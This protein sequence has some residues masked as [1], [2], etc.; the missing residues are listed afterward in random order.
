[1]RKTPATPAP[2]LLIKVAHSYFN[3][4]GP[5]PSSTKGTFAYQQMQLC[6]LSMEECQDTDLWN[7]ICWTLSHAPAH[8]TNQLNQIDRIVQT[9]LICPP[10]H[11]HTH[12][13]SHT[14]H[15]II[16]QAIL[17][18]FGLFTKRACL[19]FQC[20]PLILTMA[21]EGCACQSFAVVCSLSLKHRREKEEHSNISDFWF[22]NP[23]ACWM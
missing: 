19:L 1:M 2:L 9:G 6:S 11:T 5:Y 13:H 18:L 15:G 12:T 4:E 20:K 3:K 23:T 16:L 14:L 7:A 21:G 17:S 10:P 22:P 8:T